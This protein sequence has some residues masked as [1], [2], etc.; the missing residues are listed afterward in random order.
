MTGASQAPELEAVVVTW[1]TRELMA[2]CL[3]SLFANP[4]GRSFQVTVVDNGSADGES[5]LVR[6]D[7]PQVRLIRN[8]VNEGFTR[9]NNRAIRQSRARYLLLINADAMVTPGC[10][11]G[12]LGC[13]DADPR[14]AVAGPRLAYADGAFQRWTAGREPGLGPALVHHLALDRLLPGLARRGLYLGRD[15]KE[16]VQVDWV[17]SAC[18]L[19]RRSAL[20]EIGL[21][22]ERIFTYMDDV[23]A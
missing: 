22:D 7:W 1:N 3:R 13:L 16:A 4:P 5:E 19:V 15:L 23:D 9:A 11:D 12:L 18:L 6:R 8:Q 14:A 17:S 21:L 2:E 20:D 10:L